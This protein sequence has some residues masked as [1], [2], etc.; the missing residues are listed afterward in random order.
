MTGASLLEQIRNTPWIA[1]L[2]AQFDFDL[3]RVINGPCEPVRLPDGGALE[4][5]AGDA[6]GGAFLLADPVD[7]DRPVVYAGSEGEGGLIAPGLREALALVVACP[8]CTTP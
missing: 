2:L 5:I 8:A 7:G 1:D 6:G 3:E 4:M